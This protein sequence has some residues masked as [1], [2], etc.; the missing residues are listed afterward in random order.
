VLQLALMVALLGGCGGE[1]KPPPTAAARDATGPARVL[2]G[3]LDLMAVQPAMAAPGGEGADW[4]RD[5]ETGRACKIR[6]RSANSSAELLA[7]AAQADADLVLA[8]SDIAESLVAS[9]RVRPFDAT[10][11]P[12]MAK[13]EPRLRDLPG[14]I[15][16][17][18][19][20]GLPVRWQPN[21]LAYDT[22]AYPEPPT[23]WDLLFESAAPPAPGE[24]ARALM[25]APEPIAIADVALYLR[26]TRPELR[27]ADP[28]LLDER[29]YAAALILLHRQQ[30]VLRGSW[31]DAAT[32]AEGFRNGVSVGTST[33]AMVR[34]MQ[35]QGL[36]VAWTLPQ[37]G[38]TA[39]VE[40][41]MLH[42]SARHPNC[43]E[44]WMQWSQTP[45][46]Q[47]L[48]AARA[49]AL[50]VSPAAC[51]QQPLAGADAC[52]RDGMDLLPRLHPWRLP[53]S[54]CGRGR[55]VPYSRWTR[56][57]LTL[58]GQ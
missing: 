46:A 25:A 36:P 2:E 32:Q 42:A 23:S 9:G 5:F 56:D 29:Q 47:A 13:L 3:A 16:D 38:G 31:R 45:R 11:V 48:L 4:V 40:L 26:A 7:L 12:A 27:I 41:A 57:Y 8:G 22:T 33:P 49:G 53:G 39:Q 28:F 21:V 30:P 37:E 6:L 52:V 19:R 43:A 1:G 55:C 17:G 50:P 34:S 51:S 54:R 44:A 14:A 24:S 15:V 20:F 10:R 58:L 35:A 18:R